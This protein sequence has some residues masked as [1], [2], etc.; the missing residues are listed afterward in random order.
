MT[1]DPYTTP[2]AARTRTHRLCR[3][4]RRQRQAAAIPGAAEGAEVTGRPP[5]AQRDAILADYRA[6]IRANLIAER[7][8]V[9]AQTVRRYARDAGVTSRLNRCR[10]KAGFLCDNCEADVELTGGAWVRNGLTEKWEEYGD[11]S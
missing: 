1:R 8:G 5:N 2:R 11:A 6:G 10:C 4:E 9:S 3:T 7:Y